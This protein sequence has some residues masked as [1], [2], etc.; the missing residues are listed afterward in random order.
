MY[1]TYN[2]EGKFFK[3]SA[4][5]LE[6]IV[7]KKTIFIPNLINN[8][9]DLGSLLYRNL[10][11]GSLELDKEH[12]LIY[13]SSLVSK[14]DLDLSNIEK[15]YQNYNLYRYGN[16]ENTIENKRSFW[17]I[18][19][20][21]MNDKTL[22]L[23][24]FASIMSFVVGAYKI[25]NFSE[26]YSWIE[27]TSI[28]VAVIVIVLIGTL[29][30]Y[31]QENLFGKMDKKNTD[32]NVKVFCNNAFDTKKSSKL[33][34]GEIIYLEPGDIIPADCILVSNDKITCDESMISGESETVEKKIKNDIFLTS[35]T[36]VTEGSAKALILAVGT[37][38]VKGK[39][40]KNM[41]KPSK[42]TPLEVKIEDLSQ[43]LARKAIYVSLLLF[44]SHTI[45]G[46]IFR[47]SYDLNRIMEILIESISIIVMAVPE[48]LP[49]A[50]TIA[51]S[52]GTKRML[53]DNNLVRDVSAC[54]TMNNTN[55]ICTDKTGTL[56]K[57][58]MAV[59]YIYT[60]N[61][62][63]EITNIYGH[64]NVSVLRR[65]EKHT[66]LNHTIKNIVLN[67]SAFENKEGKYI[68]SKSESALLDILKKD[69]I[70]YKF[71][72]KRHKI[73]ARHTFSSDTKYMSTMIKYKGKYV[74]YFK[75][76]PE[77]ILENCKFEMKNDVL[78]P[79]Y[80]VSLM[81]FLEEADRMCYRT[82]VMSYIE[83][84]TFDPQAIII[85]K[86]KTTFLIA[87]ALEDPLR[88]EVSEK[89]IQCKEAGI[90]LVMLTGD[91]LFMAEYLA[92]KLKIL[93]PSYYCISGEELRSKSDDE[94]ERI[95]H[96][97]KV[98]ARANPLDK[99]RF[100]NILQKKGNIV[101]VTG[102]GSN[103]G[104]AL[105]SADVGFGMGISGTDI[106]KEASSIILLD[107]DFSSL[108]K[109]VAWGRCINNSVRKFIQF[110]LTVT[111]TTIG[112][113]IVSSLL[114]STTASAFSPI[115]LIWINILMDTLAALALST[116]EPDDYLLRRSPEPKNAPI[117]TRSMKLFIIMSSIYQFLLISLLY[118]LNLGNTFIFNT[119]IFVQLFNEI[120]AR[121]LDPFH[122][123][124]IGILKNKIFIFTNLILAM[125]QIIVVQYAGI[126][127]KT[128]PLTLNE[129]FATIFL[130]F[131]VIPYFIF[132]RAFLRLKFQR[133]ARDWKSSF[134]HLSMELRLLEAFSN[135]GD[136][137]C[138]VFNR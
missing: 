28:L 83:L 85:G 90:N 126:V 50:I 98:V 77:V 109:T 138:E 74:V 118:Y 48:G 27:G 93:T 81:D 39:I 113:A 1:D 12:L 99:K 4:E 57:N 108:I 20:N 96:K 33:M 129:M 37:H 43:N 15:I 52:F 51:L 95:I 47:T 9:E 25:I 3:L 132:I 75:G 104:P 68:G 16:N 64:Q 41:I 11:N 38:S 22:F 70:D 30:E 6:N 67:C 122:S 42:K 114:S 120:N 23:L 128:I 123:P 45:K 44:L 97:I 58:E 89:I 24:L 56:T 116:D 31:S 71:I 17:S 102:D 29:N 103:D 8:I 87:I 127:F 21:N 49:M 88:P 84:D 59:K 86:Y 82:M 7:E 124:F 134:R 19:I 66:S 18:L 63:I 131:T 137:N 80:I 13:E 100:V 125:L 110:Q 112:V 34:T 106:A 135:I 92:K 101:A 73:I 61:I 62:K 5:D 121:S 36:Y 54:E 10:K 115:K 78:K 2:L 46:I 40:M 72:R 55:Y 32:Y 14:N 26:K 91:N 117:I 76:A 35:G 111:I 130:G 53:K 133:T 79:F 105:K 119:F 69:D 60:D 136:E 65:I 94:L 107:D